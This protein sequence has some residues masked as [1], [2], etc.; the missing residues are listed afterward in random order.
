MKVLL[1]FNLILLVIFGLGL[2]ASAWYSYRLT[3]DNALKQVTDQAELI[4]Q[5]ALA[6]RSYSVKE[7]RPLAKLDSSDT[8]HP[9][10]VPA[11]AATQVSN[12]LREK[13]PNYVYKEAVFNPTNPRNKASKREE[14]IINTFINSPSM[15]KQVGNITDENGRHLYVAYPIKI[16]NPA[17]LSCHSLPANAPQAMIKVYGDKGGFGWK[18]DEIVGAQMVSVPFKLPAELAK[19]T[20]Y[21]FITSLLL[22]FSA[23]FLA[24]NYMINKIII[25][26]VVELTYMADELSKGNLDTPEVTFVGDDEIASLSSSFNRMRRSVVK[27]LELLK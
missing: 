6:V 22:M 4:M 8:F 19:K 18:T 10:T 14:E 21:S 23:L 25:N 24:L 12:I 17:C 16:T 13:R 9:Q 7:I 1:K 20:F 26:P 5:Q 2:L 11:Y 27:L 15:K 3:E